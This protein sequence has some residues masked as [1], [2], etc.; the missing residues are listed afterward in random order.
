MR[1]LFM[2]WIVAEGPEEIQ[3]T[4]RQIGH[5]RCREVVFDI[6]NCL[7]KLSAMRAS[8]DSGER[9]GR[10][11]IGSEE[12]VLYLDPDTNSTEKKLI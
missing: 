3:R 11:H 2:C 1:H 7:L 5:P 8:M 6:I 10:L 12:L 4:G 9:S